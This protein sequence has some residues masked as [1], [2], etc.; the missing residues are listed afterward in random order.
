MNH[1]WNTFGPFL[2]CKRFDVLEDWSPKASKNH[3]WVSMNNR[4]IQFWSDSCANDNRLLARK[5]EFKRTCTSHIFI[6]WQPKAG[7]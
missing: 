6:Q 2:K 5:D 3:T 1:S 7:M 4:K